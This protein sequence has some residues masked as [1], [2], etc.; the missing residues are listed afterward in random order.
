MKYF[1]Q[2][3][4]ITCGLL[5]L[6]S[7]TFAFFSQIEFF[8]AI[9]H[10]QFA[11]A[12]LHLIESFSYGVLAI[13]GLI[14]VTTFC[15][16]R[17]YCSV[18]CPMGIVQDI[19]IFLSRRKNNAPGNY[20]VVR[21][22]IFGIVVGLMFCGVYSGLLAFDPYSIYGRALGAFSLG[23]TVPL[24]VI[25]GLAFWKRRI[26]CSTIC[27]VGT[28][29]GLL[30]K[31]P[32]F[33][34][35]ISEKCVKCKKCL[36]ACPM[37]CID[38]EKK[39]IDTERCILCM[40]CVPTCGLKAIQLGQCVKSTQEEKILHDPTRRRFL[41]QGATLLAGIGVGVA[42]AKSGLSILSSYAQKL[43]I[44][45]PG[46]G[47][48]TRFASKCTGCQLCTANCPTKIITPTLEG[49]G[50]VAIDFSKGECQFDCHR[51]SAVCPTGAIRALSLAEKQKTKI[52]DV[53]FIPSRCIALH[54]EQECG[55]CADACPTGAIVLSL[56]GFPEF[57]TE[58]CI[59]CGAC[60]HACIAEPP[61]IEIIPVEK[62]TR[63]S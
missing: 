54:G 44:L 14:A 26:F 52:A 53:A 31:Y 13:V 46:A 57:K 5:F 30:S 24:M 21:Y 51:C 42:M 40:N 15:I 38:L 37:G 2:I 25:M 12:I 32:V 8:N 9:P 45:P 20:P 61:A 27:P 49:H 17:L 35:N 39:K 48:A 47:E 50:A 3:L 28:F 19:V 59:G 4:R 34:L 41:I 18:M 58:L 60:Y 29:L 23:A 11:P 63:V 6:S 22:A 43:Q 36:K 55:Y 10:T 16:G 62:Q 7:I 1:P 56:E 33:K